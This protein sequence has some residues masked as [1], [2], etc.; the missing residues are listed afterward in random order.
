MI[1]EGRCKAVAPYV[2]R[3]V[4]AAP[5]DDFTDTD[6]Y[7]S[8]SA[9]AELVARYFAFMVAIDHRLS[10]PGKPYEAEVNGKKYHGADLLYKLGAMKLAEDPEF[11]SPARMKDITKEEVLKWLAVGSAAPPDPEARAALLRDAAVKIMKLYG[12]SV[13]NLVSATTLRGPQGLLSRLKALHAYQ[14]PVEKKAFLLVK[15]LER[16]GLLRVADEENL[17]VPVDN[18]LVRIALRL[19]IVE[20]PQQLE[21]KVKDRVEVSHEEDALIRLAVRAAYKKVAV[22]AKVKP[23]IL[24]DLLWS[25]GR[26]ICTHGEP[27]CTQCPLRK[28][29]RTYNEGLEPVEEHVFWHYWY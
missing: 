23:T 9:P 19:G 4:E 11:F 13:L 26:K 20:L 28:A 10:R 18:H 8:K 22:E 5:L 21:R 24:D 12:G 7:P 2:R 27:R 25:M 6:Y 1:D 14:D 3:A 16:R 17:E 29:C 15:F